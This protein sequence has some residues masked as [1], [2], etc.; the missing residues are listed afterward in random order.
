MNILQQQES[1]FMTVWSHQ[2]K[3]LQDR[4]PLVEHGGD[5]SGGWLKEGFFPAQDLL[6]VVNKLL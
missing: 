6:E 1:K 4:K 3:I 5:T 2:A